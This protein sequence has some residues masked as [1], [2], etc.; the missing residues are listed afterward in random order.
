MKKTTTQPKKEAK[1]SK[2]EAKVEVS[3][4]ETTEAIIKP[5]EKTKQEDVPEIKVEKTARVPK[6]RSSKY[7]KTKAKIDNS[8]LYDLKEAVEI[9]QKSSLS[10]FDGNIDAHI[11]LNVEPGTIGEI[12]FPHLETSTKKIAITDD[13]L[14]KKIEKG[15]IDFDILVATPITMPKLL[16]LARILGPKGLMPNPKNGTLVNDAKEAVK[17]LQVAKMVVKTEKKFPLIHI[18]VGK[19]SQKTSEVVANIEELISV[20]KALKIKK[21]YL[22]PTMGPSVK[23]KIEK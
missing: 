15:E 17:K 23:V 10:K 20:I 9:V 8:K 6:I 1:T 3:Q 5:A 22:T 12:T 7:K 13:K 14:I 4:K 19:I 16:P 21:L 2:K 18:K 11:V